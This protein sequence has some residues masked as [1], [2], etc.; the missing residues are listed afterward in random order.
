MRIGV[1]R[2][3]ITLDLRPLGPSLPIEQRQFVRK[4]VVSV[5]AASAMCAGFS[6]SLALAAEFGRADVVDLEVAVDV[7]LE[8][9]GFVLQSLR[10]CSRVESHRLVV[11]GETGVGMLS[12][13]QRLGP[14]CRAAESDFDCAKPHVSVTSHGT[15]VTV[16]AVARPT[17]PGCKFGVRRARLLEELWLN[18]R[19]APAWAGRVVLIDH[20]VCPTIPA[21][22]QESGLELAG[23]LDDVQRFGPGCPAAT[24]S[25][26]S[27]ITWEMGA[28]V[29]ALLVADLG[30]E[31]VRLDSYVTEGEPDCGDGVI[32]AHVDTP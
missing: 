19:L 14:V 21:T 23:V 1:R 9:I 18:E 7:T 32:A 11:R 2:D 29:L 17:E 13:D 24:L 16:S 27:D 10:E 28:E 25:V 30:Y 12:I 31:F 22:V 26:A 8:T 6:S 20:G 5:E 15:Q 3:E 4:E